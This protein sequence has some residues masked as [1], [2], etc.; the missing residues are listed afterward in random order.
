MKTN[1]FISLSIVL[2]IFGNLSCGPDNQSETI[3]DG[4]PK[5]FSSEDLTIHYIDHGQ[6]I[7]FKSQN[8]TS[9]AVLHFSGLA[10]ERLMS[11]SFKTSCQNFKKKMIVRKGNLSF[12][13]SLALKDIL[14]YSINGPSQFMK[15]S[16]NCSI[17]IKLSDKSDGKAIYHMKSENEI[18]STPPLALFQPFSLELAEG[19]YILQEDLTQFSTSIRGHESADAV[20]DD[21]L[22]LMCTEGTYTASSSKVIDLPTFLTNAKKALN[23]KFSESTCRLFKIVGLASDNDYKSFETS[24]LF[25]IQWTRD[26][27]INN[28]DKG[29]RGRFLPIVKVKLRSLNPMEKDFPSELLRVTIENPNT[30]PIFMA[31]ARFTF[32]RSTYETKPLFFQN[33]STDQM[34]FNYFDGPKSASRL[35]WEI[36]TKTTIL[37]KDD[38]DAAGQRLKIDSRSQVT[39]IARGGS[40]YDLFKSSSDSNSKLCMQ[41]PHGMEVALTKLPEILIFF[42][43]EKN[44]KNELV[45]NS[46]G[47]PRMMQENVL[48]RSSLT[49][50]LLEQFELKKDFPFYFHFSDN[51]EH[52]LREPGFPIEPVGSSSEPSR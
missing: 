26:E 11:F 12:S 1:L 32:A 9:D 39:I 6:E 33:K 2:L 8:L 20:S 36:I 21:Q 14:P 25:T 49:H 41:W 19:L 5:S 10:I 23:S 16:W 18:L 34:P 47:E 52:C 4:S 38:P 15:L 3:I 22:S 46:K 40:S 13:K 37:D 29:D 31:P 17:E 51:S 24:P 43:N 42:A 45:L 35:N 27:T 50:I 44:E 30:F 7:P 48:Y 28:L